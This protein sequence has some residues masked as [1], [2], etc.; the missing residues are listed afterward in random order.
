MT[1]RDLLWSFPVAVAAQRAD[2]R[3]TVRLV[4]VPTSVRGRDGESVDGLDES[5]F[6]LLVD[7][8]PTRFQLEA[9][10]Q[11]ISLAIVVQNSAS[12]GPVIAKLQRVAGMIQPLVAGEGGSAS[13][14]E[15]SDRVTVAQEPTREV[16]LIDAAFRQ[17]RLRGHGGRML[18]AMDQASGLLEAR[19][20]RM[21]RVILLISEGRDHGSETPVEQVLERLQRANVTVYGLL[22]SPFLTAWTVKSGQR[23]GREEDGDSMPALQQGGMDL[24]PAIVG[25]AT[26]GKL[27]TGKMLA[28]FTGGLAQS[29]ARK[30][31]LE[32]AIAHAGE[33]LHSQYLLTFVDIAQPD[34]RIHRIQV[35]VNRPGAIVRCRQ[36][37]WRGAA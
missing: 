17:M 16:A 35:E 3:T 24:I 19:S 37:Y 28:Q 5:H 11:A 9:E 29:F 32:K 21:R 25:A 34:G 2:I 22:Y 12:A 13:V 6:R 33:D 36:G 18:D 14:V 15:F 4:L 26:A 23:V 20:Q 10:R 30:D 27:A 1:R 8:T 7:G 31:S